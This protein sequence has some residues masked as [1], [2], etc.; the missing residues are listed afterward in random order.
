VLLPT[1]RPRGGRRDPRG[2][3]VV[4]LVDETLRGALADVA[5]SS[6]AT[7]FMTLLAGFVGLLWHQ[8]RLEDIVVGIP[9]AGRV[10]ARS[11]EVIG[12]FLNTLPIRVA[13]DP[14]GSFE[15][16]L[17]RVRHAC[18]EA[19]EH[20]HVPFERIIEQAGVPRAVEH[21][22]I[23]QVFFQL[24]N[25]PAALHHVGSMSVDDI[26]LHTGSA[27]FDLSIDI[28]DRGDR[29][30]VR[31]EYPTALFDVAT[32]E[33]T[34]ARLQRLLEAVALDS[35]VAIDAID[36]IGA[37]ERSALSHLATP[38]DENE[39]G[40][41]VPDRI[42][43]VAASRPA[44]VAVHS[45]EGHLS[46]EEL[47]GRADELAH[48]L[49]RGGADGSLVGVCL[50][51][52]SDLP[53][54]LLGVLRA[55][56]AI[57]PLDPTLPSARLAAVMEQVGV[58]TVVTI[59]ALTTLLPSSTT[60]VLMAGADVSPP[61]GPGALAATDPRSLAY[62]MAT[63]GSTG[64][65]KCALIEHRSFANFL[66]GFA[67]RLGFDETIRMLAS[68]P[69]SF[70]PS[71]R[72]LLLPLVL[73]GEV[74]LTANVMPAD[75]VAAAEVVHE[76]A[77]SV[78][79]GTPTT[80]RLLLDAGWSPA[81][82]TTVLACGE[83]LNDAMAARLLANDAR[84][85]NL[86]GP[87]ETTQCAVVHE[88]RQTRDARDA[89]PI[90]RPLPGVVVEV[91]G[92]DL[93]PLSI[94]L[95][96]E[97]VI[98]GSGVGRGYAGFDATRDRYVTLDRGRRYR[99]G[100]VGRWRNDGNLEFLGRNDDQLKINGV[101]IELGDIESALNAH[102]RVNAAVA[103]VR[104][105]R[106]AAW[107]TVLAPMDQAEL[108][109]H[110]ATLLPA[111]MVP[112]TVVVLDR[113]P[114]LPNGKIDRAA[115]PAPTVAP[116]GVG[117]LIGPTEQRLAEMWQRVLEV[118][119]AIGRD[120]DFFALGGHSLLA[121]E[122]TTRI[123]QVFGRQVPLTQF[124]TTPT[125]ATLAAVIDE[126]PVDGRGALTDR[127]ALVSLRSGDRRRPLLL[128]VPG[129]GGTTLQL[130]RLAAALPDGVDLMG[131]E[132]A[133]HRGLPE[134]ESFAAMAQ[135]YAE[136]V[137]ELVRSGVLGSHRP[138]VLAGNSFGAAVVLE[139][140]RALHDDCPPGR[141]LLVDPLLVPFRPRGR[142]LKRRLR[143]F[144]GRLRHPT[145]R[146]H[147]AP[148]RTVTVRS[149]VRMSAR[150]RR[151]HVFQPYEG[152]V[153]IITSALRRKDLGDE[154]LHTPQFVA[155]AVE[156]HHLDG[157]HRKLLVDERVHDVASIAGQVV[158]DLAAEHR[159]LNAEGSSS[160][161]AT[162]SIRR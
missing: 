34:A 146:R 152:S 19:Y 84:L 17:G 24:R 129:S 126:A 50:P 55:G 140:A 68:T 90:G 60:I 59:D 119:P 58:A 88:V 40:W 8:T 41:T 133:P 57:V 76:Y 127:S 47:L 7:L 15:T 108:R 147:L 124:V 74:V 3:E 1:D 38:A 123:E 18:L 30:T 130:H 153:V 73:G 150:L 71:L 92:D 10:D 75:P 122:L 131:F 16:L 6:D 79:Q 98:G 51:R 87:T 145:R 25:L 91:V 5:Q 61:A 22:P 118:E 155:G 44:A 139:V 12:P 29:L 36:L 104:D 143:R 28:D 52:T 121:I 142:K 85:W 64:T 69:I 53:V 113:L 78:V 27:K 4:T 93:E 21:A 111:T 63:S 112:G 102:P 103:G 89:I 35:S 86:Y 97:I 43:A 80:L 67:T 11:A 120:D 138:F 2:A 94:G 158:D 115:L 42:A 14:H 117:G 151:R 83:R 39:A 32:I 106:L 45:P 81:P 160:S 49:R 157:D 9:V 33:R 37:T 46:Y 26:D 100:D 110:A 31:L 96:G 70:D 72:E 156:A 82:S 134:P 48:R 159:Q 135:A 128:W 107:V 95:P 66:L 132:A 136:D 114:T 149:V 62:A 161:S 99:T 56:A 141:V 144:A 109:S 116:T 105:N 13:V 148:G 77:P 20:Q 101:R 137:R 154:L 65:P 125:I 162:S 54:A 23:V